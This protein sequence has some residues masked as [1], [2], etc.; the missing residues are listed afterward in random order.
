MSTDLGSDES[1]LASALK[2]SR[3]G[4]AQSSADEDEESLDDFARQVHS[5]P[6]ETIQTITLD[7]LDD[8]NPRS[9]NV[10]QKRFSSDTSGNTMVCC[11][12]TGC[13]CSCHSSQDLSTESRPIDS[14]V[15]YL[16]DY[17]L[18][19]VPSNRLQ[20]DL[21]LEYLR[22]ENILDHCVV[23][24]V[25]SDTYRSPADSRTER[26]SLD[27]NLLRYRPSIIESVEETR[28]DV[29]R[30]FRNLIV[31]GATSDW[32]NVKASL[33][34][35]TYLIYIH[36]LGSRNELKADYVLNVDYANRVF[37]SSKGSY[38]LKIARL[39]A[40]TRATYFGIRHYNFTPLM[41][42]ARVRALKVR[43]LRFHDEKNSGKTKK[44][45]V[46]SEDE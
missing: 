27:P 37:T 45:R 16:F 39:I 28:A 22:E 10:E 15:C 12:C 18:F 41:E 31:Q 30:S 19:S 35:P 6:L 42:N 32:F 4:Y 36:L 38:G 43:A 1:L 24:S 46:K 34:Y 9:Y 25:V 17:D 29:R 20:F 8:A 26:S 23:V 13:V 5:S 7:E 3:G 2:K 40:H 44:K 11:E 21:L 33:N 14:Y